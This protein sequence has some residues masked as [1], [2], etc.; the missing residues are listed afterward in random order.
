MRFVLAAT[1]H[2]PPA[3]PA[4]ASGAT[5]LAAVALS[6]GAPLCF[7]AAAAPQ[8]RAQARRESAATA[9]ACSVGTR[10]A[11]ETRVHSALLGL[12]CGPRGLY[13]APMAAAMV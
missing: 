2:L 9:I 4:A 5:R 8:S 12:T 11:S 13:G 1:T 7:A 3:F 6:S 10:E